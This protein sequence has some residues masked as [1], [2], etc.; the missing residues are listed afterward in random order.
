MRRRSQEFWS[1]VEGLAYGAD[2]NPEQW[3]EDTWIEDAKLMKASGVNLVTLAI[4]GWASLQPRAERWEFGWLDR[5]MDLL[6]GEGIS[7][8]LA[9]ATASPP[10][11]LSARHPE[12]LPVTADGRRLWPGARQHY[13]P[14]SVEFRHAAGELVERLAERYGKHPALVCWHVGNEYGCHVAACYCDRSAEDFRRWLRERYG[15]LDSLNEAWSTSFWSQRYSEWAE[16]LPPRAA[17]TFPNPAQRLDFWRFSSDALLECFKHERDILRRITPDVAVT[18]N[19]LG[20]WK[21]LDYFAWAPEEDVVSHDSYPD[22]AEPEAHIGAAMAFD[23]MRSVGN[24][25]PWLLME[26]APSAVNW[27]E[28]NR[29]K[30]EGMYRLWSLQ[31]LAHGADGVLSFQWRASRG[32]AEKYHSAMLPHGG[33]ETRVH[34][35]VADLGQ[36]LRALAPVKGTRV[37]SETAL[38]MDWAS[39]WALEM[40]SHPS[41]QLNQLQ[42]LREYYEALWRRRLPVDI[43]GSGCDLSAYKLVIVPNLYLADDAVAAKLGEF[44]R[45]GGHLVIGPFSGIVDGADIVRPGKYPGAFRDIAGIEVEEFWPL[46]EGEESTTVFDDGLTSTARTWTEPVG[47]LSAEGIAHY[48]SGDLQGSC[49]VSRNTYGRGRV[50]YMGALLDQSGNDRV[51]GEAAETAGL[52]PVVEGLPACVE[53]TLRQDDRGSLLFL[54]N[55]SESTVPVDVDGWGKDLLGG[56]EADHLMLA[57]RGAAV[58]HKG[59]KGNSTSEKGTS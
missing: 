50:W 10:P 53:A 28:R 12:M 6:A 27:R 17:P 35:E 56:R 30:P 9:T 3:P 38:V 46:Q 33:A 31:A 48:A 2:Y 47:L 36:A 41:G 16:V 25:D 18:T 55:H 13:C 39:W 23:L 40:E 24:G 29:P 19:F 7:V 32:G 14:S 49:A 8:C 42:V 20:I 37:V 1:K 4:F 52:R 21:P 15:T 43:V 26:Q 11:W 5:V 45:G 57:P 58:L 22:P 34:R 51:L 54:L 44:A 59:R